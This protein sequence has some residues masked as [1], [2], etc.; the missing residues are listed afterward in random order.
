[1]R[2][3]HENIESYNGW[4]FEFHAKPFK[5]LECYTKPTCCA[6]VVLGSNCTL[7]CVV[8]FFQ[9][10]NSNLKLLQQALT[11]YLSQPLFGVR[12]IDPRFQ[13]NETSRG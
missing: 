7:D 10:R 1:M 5:G 2:S 8:T 6:P 3:Q 12:V 9:R 4:T 11:F 13:V